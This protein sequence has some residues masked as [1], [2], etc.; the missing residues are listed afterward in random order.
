MSARDLVRAA[1]GPELLERLEHLDRGFPAQR[2]APASVRAPDGPGEVDYDVVLAGGGL[3]L[4]LAAALAE[5][6]LRVAVCDRARVGQ[7]H[8]EWNASGPELRALVDGRIVTDAELERMVLARYRHGVC[9]WHGGGAYPVRGVLDHAVD[10]GALLGHVRALCAARGV[11]LL[12]GTPVLGERAGSGRVTVKV[13]GGDIRARLLVDARGAASP[14]ASAD[15]VCPTVGGVFEG[16]EQDPEVGEILATTEHAEEGRQH[17]WEAFPGR[18]GET[19]IYLFYYA[20]RAEPGAL[21]ELYA[22][23]FHRLGDFRKGPARLLRPTFGHIPGWTR[24]GRPPRSPSPRIVLF[25]DAAARHSPLTFCGFGAMLRTFGPAADA[26]AARL[27]DPRTLDPFPDEP[28]HAFTGALARLM[29]RPQRRPETMNAL[30]DA[31]FAS[32]QESGNDAFL[33]STAARRPSVYRDAIRELGVG[34]SLRWGWR[35]AKAVAAT[36]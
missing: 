27:D 28:V 25:G 17:L 31:A 36:P 18:P 1:G 13:F 5:R 33:R 8:R 9:R 15:I 30:L 14:Y 22:R 20:A 6:G 11:A 16:L 19:T 34:A 10:A 24:L 12:D 4:L 2:H 3:S 29:S 35:L 23:L 21:V 32:L 7:A 26:I